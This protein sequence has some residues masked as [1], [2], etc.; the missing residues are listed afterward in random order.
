MMNKVFLTHWGWVTYICVNKLTIIGSDNGL[1][2]GRRQAI[3]WTNAGILLN[4]S[5]VTKFSEI[6]IEI[7]TFLFKKIFLKMSSVKCRPFCLGLNVLSYCSTTD[8]LVWKVCM[9]C[10]VWKTLILWSRRTFPRYWI[11]SCLSS[12]TWIQ[13]HLLHA[14]VYKGLSF[15]VS[16]TVFII[17][18]PINKLK[19]KHFLQWL[20]L[21]WSVQLY[22]YSGCYCLHWTSL[23]VTLPILMR[24]L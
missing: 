17:R 3:P 9:L 11:S 4:G 13:I 5:L 12:Y 8:M 15:R 18:H 24:M 1:S 7:H 14:C 6:L 22:S 21:V 19:I 10:T 2:P 23:F 20:Q 16:P